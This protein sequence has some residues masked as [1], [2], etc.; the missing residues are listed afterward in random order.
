MRKEETGQLPYDIAS[1]ESIFEYSKG[2]LGKTLRDFVWEDYVPKKGKGGLGQMVENIYFLLETNN[3]PEADFS[4]AGMELKCTPLK[5]GDK[6]ELLIKERLVCNM[7]N[8]NNLFSTNAQHTLQGIL[9]QR[10]SH[11]DSSLW[12]LQTDFSLN[13]IPANG[14]SA[15]YHLDNECIH[16]RCLSHSSRLRASALS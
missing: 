5:K 8:F 3:N 13:R 14:W 9:P 16:V 10:T 1:A 12:N 15:E 11:N 4:K 7:I 2:L 6:E